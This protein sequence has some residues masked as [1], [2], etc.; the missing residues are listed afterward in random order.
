MGKVVRKLSMSEELSTYIDAEAQK[1]ELPSNMWLVALI[2]RYR[3]GDLV[4]AGSSTRGR[5]AK[6][7]TEEEPEPQQVEPVQSEQESFKERVLRLQKTIADNKAL[8]HSYMDP[9]PE[10]EKHLEE[11]SWYVVEAKK[12]WDDAQSELDRIT[13]CY[14]PME[15]DPMY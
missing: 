12:L 7:H 6:K 15:P 5:P 4:P 3:N 11:G 1:M 8:W 9:I 13:A 10:D 2:S 14:K